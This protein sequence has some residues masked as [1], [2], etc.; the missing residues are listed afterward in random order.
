MLSGGLTVS[1]G[2]VGG[3]VE[4]GAAHVVAVP[5]GADAALLLA[6]VA[7]LPA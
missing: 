2:Q 7:V 6:R 5:L 1:L 4:V 3:G